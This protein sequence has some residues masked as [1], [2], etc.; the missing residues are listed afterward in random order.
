MAPAPLVNSDVIVGAVARAT[1]PMPGV[2]GVVAVGEVILLV[3]LPPGD[4]S[5][6]VSSGAGAA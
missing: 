2:V 3:L 4:L 6:D 1:L 5:S